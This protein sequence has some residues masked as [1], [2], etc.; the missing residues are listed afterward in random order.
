MDKTQF[1]A[2]ISMQVKIIY[3]L[4]TAFGLT[5]IAVLDL[6]EEQKRFA[7]IAA[8]FALL[9]VLYAVYL[10]LH[11]HKTPSLYPEWLLVSLLLFF[12]LFG[13]HEDERV[14]HWVYFVPIYT[15][16]LIPFRIASVALIVYTAV[17]VFMVFEQ[18]PL[19]TRWQILFTY[20]ACLSFSF[21]Y[22]LLNERNNNHLKKIINTD[23]VTQVYNEHQLS[24][25]LNK[26]IIRANRHSRNESS[27]CL[28]E[29]AI[30]EQW[31]QLRLEE[32]EKKLRTVSRNMRK[33]LLQY[34]SC[35]RLNNNN[36]VILLPQVEGESAEAMQHKL[37]RLQKAINE[38]TKASETIL[39]KRINTSPED[40]LNSLLKKL[41][42]ELYAS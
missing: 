18:F 7:I 23:P 35:Y 15:F 14:V 30:P 28:V 8:G 5:I 40:D 10:L 29:V 41:G 9:L 13:M 24:N 17:L 1:Q 34:D 25:D 36:F 11:K 37:S 4:L 21:M 16:F 31:Q 12:T 38:N 22:A 27:L 2:L 20:G 3:S 39:V 6:Y 42:G 33:E 32:L 26:E 19:E